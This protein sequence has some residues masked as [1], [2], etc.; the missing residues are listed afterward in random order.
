MS[1]F[2]RFL[3]RKLMAEADGGSPG[4]ASGSPP[5][6]SDVGGAPAEGSAGALPVSAP[7]APPSPAFDANASYQ[8][9]AGQYRSLHGQ[10]QELA[11]YVQQSTDGNQQ[12]MKGLYDLFQR[13]TDPEG[14]KKSQEPQYVQANTIP[15]LRQQMLQEMR[16]MMMAERLR[17]EMPLLKERFPR[18]AN[19]R[20]QK[21]VQ[22]AWINSE[23]HRSL[24]DTAKDFDEILSGALTEAQKQ[25]LADKTKQQQQMRS[26]SGSA[27]SPPPTTPGRPDSGAR[28]I[29]RLAD[30]EITPEDLQ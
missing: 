2:L 28:G 29:A 10:A 11:R 18:L 23:G 13:Q 4:G 1:A 24:L 14:Y 3:N 17:D 6:G 8:E 25:W 19:E 20:A 9:L 30:I 27:G 16:Q 21:L 26:G 7:A 15:Q 22:A 5:P 12:F